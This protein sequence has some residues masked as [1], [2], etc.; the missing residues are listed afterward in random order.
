[1]VR[2]RR[3]RSKGDGGVRLAKFGCHKSGGAAA[4]AFVYLSGGH[5]V[6]IAGLLA[7]RSKL[8]LKVRFVA[9]TRGCCAVC[10]RQFDIWVTTLI[11]LDSV[12]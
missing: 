4:H 8:V 7:S 11:G 2:V 3:A 6:R 5:Y 10:R 1:V 12:R 9:D